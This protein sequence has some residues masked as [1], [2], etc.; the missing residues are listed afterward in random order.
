MYM[1]AVG[2]TWKEC[3]LDRCLLFQLHGSAYDAIL[4]VLATTYWVTC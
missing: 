3:T 4:H 2:E 1:E